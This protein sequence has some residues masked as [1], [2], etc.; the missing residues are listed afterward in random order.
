MSELRGV[1]LT[2]DC[3]EMQPSTNFNDSRL[4]KFTAM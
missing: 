3:E 1:T 2:I 4:S